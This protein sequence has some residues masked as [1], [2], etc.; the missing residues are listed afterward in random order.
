MGLTFL[1][2]IAM[3]HN[4]REKPEMSRGAGYQHPQARS[5]ERD[6]YTQGANKDLSSLLHQVSPAAASIILI[7]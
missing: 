5:R 4:G 7:I 3:L 2:Y 6:K 1:S